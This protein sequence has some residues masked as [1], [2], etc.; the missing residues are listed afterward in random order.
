MMLWKIEPKVCRPPKTSTAAFD[1]TSGTNPA[2]AELHLLP[3]RHH[4][5]PRPPPPSSPPRP[6][7]AVAQPGR[8]GSDCR[9]HSP[10]VAART[11][12]QSTPGRELPP[13]AQRGPPG[14][15]T[16]QHL[17]NC[18]RRRGGHQ[19][20]QCGV[21]RTGLQV[22]DHLGPQRQVWRRRG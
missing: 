7:P 11:G 5:D 16:Q 12:R 8:P 13:G 9:R 17:G 1:S 19:A 3:C 6:G 21:P 15:V 22:R 4:H 10:P 18:L 14:G 2:D 20:G